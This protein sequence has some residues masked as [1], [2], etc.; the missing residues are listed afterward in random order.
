MLC[1]EHK[2]LEVRTS[3][4]RFFGDNDHGVA[5][6]QISLLLQMQRST[7]FAIVLLAR[8]L[9]GDTSRCQKW[10]LTGIM[11]LRQRT[12]LQCSMQTYHCP[13]QPH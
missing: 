7:H 2:V 8:V 12:D 9:T 11:R 1:F 5:R 3:F 13:T 10:Q 6:H 4:F